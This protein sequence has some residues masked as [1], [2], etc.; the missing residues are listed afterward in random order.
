MYRTETC[1]LEKARA[2]A[3]DQQ[4]SFSCRIDA[5]LSVIAADTGSKASFL[6]CVRVCVCVCACVCVYKQVLVWC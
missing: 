4:S 3:A 2:S 1:V 5:L 6:L